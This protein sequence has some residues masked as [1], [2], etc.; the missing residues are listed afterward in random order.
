MDLEFPKKSATFE[1]S[2]G[3]P[4]Q[5]AGGKG[6][7]PNV[8]LCLVL[9]QGKLQAWIQIC[10]YAWNTAFGPCFLQ[11][12]FCKAVVQLCGQQMETVIITKSWVLYRFSTWIQLYL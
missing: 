12:T 2:P 5:S 3:T 1:C 8:Q 6:V 4:A 11:R 9:S 10:H 7:H